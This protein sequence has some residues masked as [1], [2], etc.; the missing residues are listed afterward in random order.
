MTN[1]EKAFCRIV[2]LIEEGK[3][4]ETD[5]IL[6]FVRSG[7]TDVDTWFKEKTPSMKFN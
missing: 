3:I 6:D 5:E 1:M 2:D 7:H 4:T